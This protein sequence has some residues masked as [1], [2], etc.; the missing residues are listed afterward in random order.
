VRSGYQLRSE[1]RPFE[2]TA[3]WK[4]F[5]LEVQAKQTATLVI[6]EARP[7]MKALKGSA[8]ERALLQ[9]TH[10]SPMS[11]KP[12]LDKLRKEI[13]QPDVQRESPPGGP[14]PNDPRAFLRRE[15]LKLFCLTDD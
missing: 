2:T 12:R 1:P 3:A 9:A 7:V 13:Q 5:R 15:A 6:E 11:G 4:R 8:E 14:R 10:S